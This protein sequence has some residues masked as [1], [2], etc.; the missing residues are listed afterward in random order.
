MVRG[1]RD[2]LVV[3]V[4]VQGL[5]AAHHGRHRLHRRAHHV[6]EG[7]LLHESVPARL[8]VGAQHERLLRGGVESLFH[9]ARPEP[10]RST[11]L[12]H[13]GVEVHADRKEEREPLGGVVD[14]EPRLSPAFD[15]LQ[16]VRDG[17]GELERRRGP[18]LLHVVPADADGMEEGHVAGRVRHDV[19][20][21]PHG[22]RGR[23]DE[24]V[25]DHELLEDV[26]LDGAPEPAPCHPLLLRRHDEH[27]KHGQHRAIH[28]H[29]DAHLLEG[30][31]VE[32][33]L[34]VLHGVDGH[35]GHAHVALHAGV[36]R[37]VPAVRGKVKGDGEPLLAGCNALAVELVRILGRGEARILP[38]RP[39]P[40]RV[41]G[42]IRPAGVGE[43]PGYLVP[44]PRDGVEVCGCVQRLDA[45]SLRRC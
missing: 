43:H 4:G 27:G 6:V 39:R 41:H 24:G 33:G 12:G 44:D 20:H 21:D 19:P 30:D 37:V 15:V 28:G 23:V 8:A 34:H 22:G 10:P 18:G 45:H 31:V 29:R 14:A 11:Q 26:V 16:P 17:E 42:S 5:S 40:L 3:G 9:K 1:Q 35:A 13:L 38:Y 25:A 7:P 2:G 32:E 36:V